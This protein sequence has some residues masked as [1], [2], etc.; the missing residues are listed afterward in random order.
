MNRL[1]KIGKSLAKTYDGTK[2]LHFSQWNEALLELFKLVEKSCFNEELIYS[3][4]DLM[5]RMNF[6]ESEALI[7]KHDQNPI[8]GVLIY[9]DQKDGYL[10]ID[11]LAVVK[12]GLGIGKY[13]LSELINRA[14]KEGL[15]G[16]CLDTEEF[17]HLG[18]NLTKY[19]QQ[20][21]FETHS[22]DSKTGNVHLILKFV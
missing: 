12:R 1:E 6:L 5:E 4:K 20:F 22:T 16:I 2:F 18:Q 15:N 19:Y 13:I 9:L 8:A 11:T 3:K 17:N 14:K 21:G 10:Y 7:L